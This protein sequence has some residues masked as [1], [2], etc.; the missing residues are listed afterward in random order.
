LTPLAWLIG[1]VWP[2]CGFA[3]ADGLPPPAPMDM[4]HIQHPATPNAA[5]AAP[6]GF[7]P[8]PDIT[9]Q[10][11]AVAPDRL[12]SAI[13]HVAD[14]QPRTYRAA[15]FPEIR[16]VHYVARS[17]LFNFPDLIAVQ[18]DAA[19]PGAPDATSSS[20]VLFSRSV[21][22]RSD[23]GVNQA[24]LETWL[25]ALDTALGTTLQQPAER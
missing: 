4:A 17:A 22:G 21:Y 15:V 25:S 5:L 12:L 19:P 11:Y 14:T 7:Q 8:G 13:E 24:R 23:L 10:T 3:G 9:T 6:A 2:A 16:Q 20:L 1:F 18:V